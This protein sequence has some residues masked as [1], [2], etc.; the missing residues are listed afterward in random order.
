MLDRSI[1]LRFVEDERFPQP[2]G[3]VLD[4]GRHFDCATDGR[5]LIALAGSDLPMP[6]APT[7]GCI[8]LLS[9]AC[10]GPVVAMRALKRWADVPEESFQCHCGSDFAPR[11]RK[12]RIGGVLVNRNLFALA[13]DPFTDERARVTIVGP[14]EPIIVDGDG[15]RAFVMGMSDEGERDLPEFDVATGTVK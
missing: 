2:F 15:W 7:E 4:D 8:A 14:L 11:I 13:L 9:R 3:I 1:L 10:A 6:D 12:G 5:M